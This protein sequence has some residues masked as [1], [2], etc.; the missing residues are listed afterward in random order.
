MTV[1][2]LMELN[3]MITDL[4]ITVRNKDGLLIDQLN[5]GMGVGIKPPYPTRV[6]KKPEFCINGQRMNEKFYRDAAYIRKSI[7]SWDDGADG[8]RVKVS[9]VPAKWLDLDVRDW[10]VWEAPLSIGTRRRT[11]VGRNI[12]FHGQRLNVT[13]L[14]SGQSLEIVERKTKE[15]D[16]VMDGQ[17][18]I[19]D[20]DFGGNDNG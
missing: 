2:E 16:N 14:P 17:M 18:S 7:N 9:A 10:E 5:I 13:T 1:K 3:A 11:E 15:E 19:A 4:V 8:W 6:P 12:N 20:W